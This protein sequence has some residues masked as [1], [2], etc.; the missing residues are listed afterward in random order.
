MKKKLKFI[1]PI[2][3]LLIA[4]GVYYKMSHKAKPAKLKVAGA[5]YL[6]PQDFLINLSDGQFAKIAVALVLAPGQSDGS[7]AADAGAA[8]GGSSD[9]DT[10]GTLPE[11]ALVRS[12]ITNELTNDSSTQLLGS[13]S[14]A[15][16]ERQ[17]LTEIAKQTDVKVTQV[18]IPDLTV[19]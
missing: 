1:L 7:S 4:G 5:I 19:Q 17:I 18:L 15:E 10:I 12:I 6:L 16:I 9:G 3:I 11:E 2:V 13:S 8:A 14:R